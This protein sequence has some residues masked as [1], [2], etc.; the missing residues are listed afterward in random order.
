MNGTAHCHGHR[1]KS[2]CDP[3]WSGGLGP[4][5]SLPLVS[6]CLRVGAAVVPAPR[7]RWNRDTSEHAKCLDTLACGVIT[8][9]ALGR[10]PA[11]G[12]MCHPPTWGS[13]STGGVT[14]SAT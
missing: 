3:L 7:G 6:L 10:G 13:H 12:G 2:T 9:A 4:E 14:V 1:V 8:M 5:A 11:A